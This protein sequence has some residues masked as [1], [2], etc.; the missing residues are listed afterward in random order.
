M[1]CTLGRDHLQNL[2]SDTSYSAVDK[3]CKLGL[4]LS[5]GG[6]GHS[7]DTCQ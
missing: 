6:S 4:V 5:T 2:H 3:G 1:G 7:G